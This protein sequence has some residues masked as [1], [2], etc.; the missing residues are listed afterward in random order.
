MLQQK[1]RFTTFWKKIKRSISNQ[2]YK[3]PYARGSQPGIIYGLFKFYKLLI[4]NFPKLCPILSA[5]N[6]PTGSWAKVFVRLPKSFSVNACTLKGSFEFTK[7]I[8]DQSS[9][10]FYGIIRCGLT[11]Y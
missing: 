5:I 4:N 6:T 8:T 9:N 2:L 3:E 7:V 11:F 1:D 10:F